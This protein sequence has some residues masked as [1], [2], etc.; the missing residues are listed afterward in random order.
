MKESIGEIISEIVSTIIVGII[1]IP[2]LIYIKIKEIKW[3]K[4]IIGIITMD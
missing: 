2:M 1:V 3:K 4:N